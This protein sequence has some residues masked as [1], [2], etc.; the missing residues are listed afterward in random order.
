MNFPPQA[1]KTFPYRL[2]ARIGLMLVFIVQTSMPLAANPVPADEAS[3]GRGAQS[4]QQ[5]CTEC[6]GRDGRAQMDVIS[7][8][9]D[10]TDPELYYNGT[11]E[12]DIYNSIAQGAGVG[13]P[14]WQQQLK[15]DEAIWDLVNFI[16]NW[17]TEEQRAEL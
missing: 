16:R 2:V 7:D 4:F 1:R 13:M 3:I 8:A 9:T 15:S 11:A 17:W 5:Y 12:Q 10:L 6:H 14:P